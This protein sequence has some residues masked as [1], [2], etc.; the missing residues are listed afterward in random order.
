MILDRPL[1]AGERRDSV[2]NLYKHTCINGSA[3]ACVGEA[4]MILLAVNLGCPDSVSAAIGAMVYVGFACLPLG[5]IVTARIGAALCSSVF[6]MIRNVCALFIA[7]AFFWVKAGHPTIGTITILLGAFGF[8]GCRSAA[9]VIQ[10]PLV[11]EFALEEDQSRI[12]AARDGLFYVFE[13]VA[14]V[15]IVLF[16]WA[17][18]GT[19]P[20]AASGIS[21]SNAAS[22]AWIMGIGSCLGIWSSYYLGRLHES[23]TLRDGAR[24]PVRH[25]LRELL[26]IPSFR[27]LLF[28]GSAM[29]VYAM[30]VVPASMLILKRG[31]GVSDF[32][33]I[34]WSF[35]QIAAGGL[36]AFLTGPLGRRIGPRKEILWAYGTMAGIA[37]G[38][39]ALPPDAPFAVHAAAWLLLFFL[40]GFCKGFGESALS[41]YF[42]LDTPARLRISGSTLLYTSM[43]L[44]AGLIGLGISTTLLSLIGANEA[45]AGAPALRAYR[46]YFCCLLLLL[47]GIVF[48]YRLTPLTPAQ[49]AQIKR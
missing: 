34:L 26:G 2:R 43:G 11:G 31:Y 47:S 35:A 5:R 36:G 30:L 20:S 21:L 6:W 42:L 1:T 10:Q 22:L 33:A 41:H 38:W 8:Y 14:Y 48:P 13:G 4:M 25:E 40:C 7:S 44:C 19:V 39:I 18:G 27:K 45:A 12:I 9:V 37:I 3:Y 49:R 24:K 28:A 32:S 17:R 23:N 46:I 16:L 29:N 15:G